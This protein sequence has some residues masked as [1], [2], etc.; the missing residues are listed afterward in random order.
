MMAIIDAILLNGALPGVLIVI[1]QS[2][3][4]ALEDYALR[5]A[6]SSL[7]ALFA[8]LPRIAHR[9]KGDSIE[10]IVDLVTKVSPYNI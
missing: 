6:S 2:G 8:R 1:M 9:R 10:E 7:D 4:K 3:G 5:Q